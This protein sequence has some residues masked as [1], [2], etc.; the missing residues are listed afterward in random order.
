[1]VIIRIDKTT[2]WVILTTFVIGSWFSS[3]LSISGQYTKLL[4]ADRSVLERKTIK[5]PEILEK[6]HHKHIKNA[7][8]L[9]NLPN[10]RDRSSL[11]V[12]ARYFKIFMK[13]TRC[14]TLVPLHLNPIGI[15]CW[16][17]AG[18][19]STHSNRRDITPFSAC[20]RYLKQNHKAGASK[21]S[22]GSQEVERYR[23]ALPCSRIN[24]DTL[25]TMTGRVPIFKGLCCITCWGWS[26]NRGISP[27]VASSRREG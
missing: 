1:M 23:S 24:L 8:D 11:G 5:T 15:R 26:R 19:C 3:R 12:Q 21:S 27:S 18:W 10:S 9:L 4:F 16:R 6:W 14:S 25:P 2:L 7:P 22:A 17:S 13:R 20:I